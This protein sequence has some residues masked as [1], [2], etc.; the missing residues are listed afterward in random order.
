M[1][2]NRNGGCRRSETLVAATGTGRRALRAALEVLEAEG[3]LWR[4][5]RKGTFAGQRPDIRP[6][7]VATIAGLP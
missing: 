6:H 5:Q 2:I 7:L 3:R 4:H 1:P